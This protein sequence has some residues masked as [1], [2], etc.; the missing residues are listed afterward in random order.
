MTLVSRMS[1]VFLPTGICLSISQGETTAHWQIDNAFWQTSRLIHQRTK[2][3]K[4]FLYGSWRS[5]HLLQPWVVFLL[6][7]S[8]S[9]P[10]QLH[11]WCVL[12]MSSCMATLWEDHLGWP[13]PSEVLPL[14]FSWVMS[15]QRGEYRSGGE[16]LQRKYSETCIPWVKFSN[17]IRWAQQSCLDA[18]V[19]WGPE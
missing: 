4:H 18:W 2:A 3:G 11:S 8:C 14:G 1:H 5:S 10:L 13:S 12:L 19:P 17:P 16:A 7:Y 6:L 9:V 15:E